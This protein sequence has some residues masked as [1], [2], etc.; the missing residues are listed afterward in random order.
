LVYMRCSV[1]VELL[2]GYHPMYCYLCCPI[3]INAEMLGLH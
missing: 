2:L 3:R 1:D